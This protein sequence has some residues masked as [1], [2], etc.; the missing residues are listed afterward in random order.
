MSNNLTIPERIVQILIRKSQVKGIEPLEYLIQLIERDLDP[1]SRI[2][3]YVKNSEYF[4]NE[5]LKMFKEGDIRQA[6]E[7]FWNSI[8]QLIKAI[9]EKKGLKHD[10]HRLIWQVVKVLAKELNKRE[11]IKLFAEI[12]Q[13][14]INFY[15]GHL[16]KEEV[17]I[18]LESAHKLRDELVKYLAN[19]LR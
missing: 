16:D 14:H 15:E 19:I 5:G 1:D 10:S 2:E 7:K 3:F 18:I 6:S 9:A 11:L 13:F 12:E 8:I 4:W 17:E